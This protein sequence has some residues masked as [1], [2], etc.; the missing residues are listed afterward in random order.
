[1]CNLNKYNSCL[2]YDNIILC[3]YSFITTFYQH[4][5]LYV[6]NILMCFI[7]MSLLFK[8]L[9]TFMFR[10]LL[11]LF[12]FYISCLKVFHIFIR[13]FPSIL[14]FLFLI[15]STFMLPFYCIFLQHLMSWSI[16]HMYYDFWLVFLHAMFPLFSPLLGYVFVSIYLEKACI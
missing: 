13:F 11:H 10:F 12:I 2:N 8:I 1:M 7:L 6:S 9:C 4:F 5:F 15:L 14:V 3:Y 16:S